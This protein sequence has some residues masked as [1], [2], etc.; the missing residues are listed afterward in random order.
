MVV[1]AAPIEE[2]DHDDYGAGVS[3]SSQLVTVDARCDVHGHRAP[4]FHF[5]GV[6]GAEQRL[7]R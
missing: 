6:L 2:P 5:D 1:A 7:Q 3:Q 4:G